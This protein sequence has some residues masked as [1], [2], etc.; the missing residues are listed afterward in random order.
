MRI[1]SNELW[2]FFS[3]QEVMARQFIRILKPYLLDEPIVPVSDQI[4]LQWSAQP[5]S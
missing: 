1:L 5:D 2:I 3:N 4:S